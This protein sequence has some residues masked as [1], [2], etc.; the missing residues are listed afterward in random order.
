[1]RRGI[2]FGSSPEAKSLGA[3]DLRLAS[4]PADDLGPHFGSLLGEKISHTI[5][6]E[7]LHCHLVKLLGRK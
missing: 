3:R 1:L 5:V 6:I 4:R 7:Q 2:A